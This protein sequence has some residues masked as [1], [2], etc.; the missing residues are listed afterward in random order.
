MRERESHYQMAEQ[1][2]NDHSSGNHHHQ[3]CH[4]SGGKETR[5][6]CLLLVKV[7]VSHVFPFSTQL[8]R[9]AYIQNT[10]FICSVSCVARGARGGFL[11]RLFLEIYIFFLELKFFFSLEKIFYS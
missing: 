11:E 7:A 9:S 3:Y 5:I 8:A 4:L 6:F 10:L 1:S 2:L